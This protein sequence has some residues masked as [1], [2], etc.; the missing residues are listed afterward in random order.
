MT[1]ASPT[2]RPVPDDSALRTAQHPPRSDPPPQSGP[3]RVRAL[4]R[5]ALFLLVLVAAA[6]LAWK[7][8]AFELRDRGTLL[9]TIREV[10]SHRLLVPA[11]VAAYVVAVTFGLPAS[12]LTLAGG[13]LFGFWRGF[14]LNWLG[15]SLGAFL[16]FLFAGSLCREACRALLGRRAETMERLAAEHGFLGTLRLRLLP[17]VPFS[18]LNFAAAL[19][20]VRRR[21]Y[22][23]ATVLGIIPGTAVYTY[24]ADSLLLGADGAGRNALLRVAMAGA[25]LLALSFVPS[26][27]RR[28]KRSP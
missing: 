24:F 28:G 1:V 4:G 8:G 11:F 13:A 7:L 15:A 22:L 9:A 10:Q 21:D 23:A 25:L 19:A 18:L 16:A 17:V 3:N 6:L 14:L 26:L 27:L 2:P 5:A 12:P 20:G